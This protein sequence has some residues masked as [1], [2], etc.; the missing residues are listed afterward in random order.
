MSLTILEQPPTEIECHDDGV[1]Q[2]SQKQW[3][4]D[5]DHDVFLTPDVLPR[6]IAELQRCMEAHQRRCQV[7][8]SQPTRA[9]AA[10][11][12]QPT[13]TKGGKP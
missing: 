13:K 3:N 11:P 7:A 10:T 2:F 9:A 8:P 12:T 4:D 1:V 6:V 5:R